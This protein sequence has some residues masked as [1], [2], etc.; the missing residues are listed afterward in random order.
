MDTAWKFLP[1]HYWRVSHLT[2]FLSQTVGKLSSS[3]RK[4]RINYKLIYLQIKA[5]TTPKPKV[6]VRRNKNLRKENI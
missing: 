3:V 5:I 1:P 2:G 6:T 4:Q